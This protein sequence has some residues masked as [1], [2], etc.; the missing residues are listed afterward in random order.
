MH[1]SIEQ[2]LKLTEEP[3]SNASVAAICMEYGLKKQTMA[4]ITPQKYSLSSD[5]EGAS[6]YGKVAE[7]N[8]KPWNSVNFDKA[9]MKWYAQKC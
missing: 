5:A 1:I 7:G 4:N 2:N 9:V 3:Q 8:A 6:H